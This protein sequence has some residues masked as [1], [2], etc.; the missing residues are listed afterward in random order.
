MMTV[1]ESAESLVDSYIGGQPSLGDVQ[2]LSGAIKDTLVTLGA[3][4]SMDMDWNGERRKRAWGVCDAVDELLEKYLPYAGLYEAKV[5]NS[6]IIGKL[7]EMG[8]TGMNSEYNQY[9]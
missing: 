4:Q 6:A 1:V 2:T 8:G 9:S 3:S 5:L 7:A